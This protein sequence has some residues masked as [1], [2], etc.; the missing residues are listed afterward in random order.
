MA[1]LRALAQQRVED[2]FLQPGGDSLRTRGKYYV[3]LGTLTLSEEPVVTNRTHAWV[4]SSLTGNVIESTNRDTPYWQGTEANHSFDR[5]L[6]GYPMGFL[7]LKSFDGG[8]T[9]ESIGVYTNVYNTGHDGSR[10]ADTRARFRLRLFEMGQPAH[11]DTL[12]GGGLLVTD[13]TAVN[14]FGLVRYRE[15]NGYSQVSSAA[16]PSAGPEAGG[17]EEN[18][19]LLQR[20]SRYLFNPRP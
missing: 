6:A 12:S 3:A 13:Y 17:P 7:G 10:M 1:I 16:P 8:Q 5:V 9:V 18:M 14:R 11:A 2:E 19:T 4:V 20:W 15:L